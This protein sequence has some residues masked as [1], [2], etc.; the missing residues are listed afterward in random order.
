[1]SGRLLLHVWKHMR[2]GVEGEG[3]ACVPQLFG[4][5]L[6]RNTGAERQSRRCVTQIVKPDARQF[7]AL[8]NDLKV[9][10][11]EIPFIR[12]VG[13]RIHKDQIRRRDIAIAGVALQGLGVAVIAEKLE[14]RCLRLH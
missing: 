1:M 14:D 6:G 10:L 3:N 7:G 12:R 9:P 5:N 2:I 13:A 8:E 4:D 11:H